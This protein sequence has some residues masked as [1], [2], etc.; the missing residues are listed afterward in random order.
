MA[1]AL[2]LRIAILHICGADEQD[3]ARGV[4]LACRF[5]DAGHRLADLV[6]IPNT[7]PV[8][9][10]QMAIWHDA[11]DIDVVLTLPLKSSALSTA[12]PDIAVGGVSLRD[13]RLGEVHVT[14]L[15]SAQLITT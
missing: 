7:A 11:G 10:R 12:Q 13:A 9:A 15:R 6:V 5:A 1:R 2:K 4:D 3:D 14:H 8:A